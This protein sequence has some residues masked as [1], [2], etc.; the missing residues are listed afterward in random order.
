MNMKKPLIITLSFMLSLAGMMAQGSGSASTMLPP[1][2]YR[3]LISKSDLAYDTPANTSEEGMPIGNG[4]MGTLVWTTP[5]ALRFQLNR[6]DVFGND[7]SSNNFAQRNTDYCGGVGFLDIDFPGYDEV[8]TGADFHQKL[9]CYEAVVTTNGKQVGT[10][11]FVW[12][13]GD[14]MAIK[15]NDNR[16]DAPVVVRLRTLRPPMTTRGD[17]RAIST[18]KAEGVDKM[19]L[20]QTFS[21]GDFLCKSAMAV[22]VSGAGAKAWKA[23]DSE[24]TLTV[25]P[26][27]GAFY[28]FVSSAS[29]FDKDADVAAD[30]LGK[31][32]KAGSVGYDA[33]L[34]SHK[35]W[36]KN[37]WEQS[38]VNLSST[39]GV[40][41]NITAHYNYFMYLMGSASRG[42]YQ[43]KFN[44]MLW[45]TGG[46]RRQWGGQFW[47]ANQSCFFNGL[48]PANRPE[49]T[50]PF[51]KMY[52]RMIPSLERAAEQQW[53]SKGIYIPETVAFNGMSELPDDI[54]AEMRDLYLAR[55]P[56]SEVSPKFMEYAATK[57]PFNSRWN[58][59]KDDGWENGVWR[60]SDKG[61]GGFAQ[62]SHIFSRGAKIAY[63]YWMQYEYTQDKEWLA[64][65]AYPMVK[66][67]AEFYRNFPNLKKEQDGKYHINYVNDNESVWGGRDTVEEISSIM[68]LFP[69]AIKAAE[70]LNV[71]E[72]LRAAWAEVLANLAPLPLS[73]EYPQFDGRPVT[74]V[75]GHP[76]SR[77]DGPVTGLPDSN[78]MPVWFFDLVTLESTDKAMMTIANNTYDA[79]FRRG[80]GR[81][82][83]RQA[84][85]QATSQQANGITADRQIGILSKLP[86]TG[87]L[88][89]RVDATRYLIPSQIRYAGAPA[90]RSVMR[91]RLDLSE[92]PQTTNVQRLGR[93]TDALHN[94]LCQSVPAKPGE[95]TVIRVFPA[96]PDE[97][98]AQF[99]LLCRGNF[100]VTS[101][102]RNGTT[103]FVEIKSQAG[104]DCKMRNPWGNEE[105]TIYRNGER[106]Q[107]TKDNLIAFPT[108]TNDVFVIVKGDT[109]I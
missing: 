3:A 13:D 40:A 85:P 90:G 35:Q 45:T 20:T 32:A 107:Q 108:K 61:G 19:T 6:V 53:G 38:L 62:V 100:L 89:G 18:L 33:M 75:R 69:V 95:D 14:V 58:W 106:L 102:F 21:E 73:S 77:N 7:D 68:G 44:G 16:K 109:K 57:L 2:D 55:K 99:T 10:E 80:G 48:F 41:D 47:G 34:A 29:T 1:V 88:M 22:T 101:S 78:T 64:S 12:S 4:V 36:W 83:S 46:D 72:D 56:W 28:I 82:A 30:A 103:E 25:K 67:V 79:Y 63:Q 96:W 86:V 65:R 31:L 87:A 26:V 24:M 37:F 84:N 23:N 54:A 9:S 42:E 39:D 17:H 104:K 71:D 94:A 76:P 51:F 70:I 50:Q 49:L 93:M 98:S 66:G 60:F 59:K 43:A 27:N 52:S 81:N 8:F 92:G 15:V 5:S 91:N 11:A 74:F 97:W 105:V